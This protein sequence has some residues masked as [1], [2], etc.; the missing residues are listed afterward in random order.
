MLK[1]KLEKIGFE[2][3]SEIECEYKS[4]KFKGVSFFFNFFTFVFSIKT[5]N[6]HIPINKFINKNDAEQSSHFEEITKIF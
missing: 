5:N 1:Q 2:P 6:L 3:V 4:K